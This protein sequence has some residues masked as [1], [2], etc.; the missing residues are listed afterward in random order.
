MQHMDRSKFDLAMVDPRYSH[1]TPV[2]R[3][4]PRKNVPYP[5]L[6]AKHDVRT[7]EEMGWARFVNGDLPR[8][9]HSFS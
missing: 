1:G 3:E 4:A 7:A 9:G 5:L 2:S 6:L 8:R